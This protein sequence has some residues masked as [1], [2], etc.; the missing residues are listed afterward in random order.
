[1]KNYK[2]KDLFDLWI[3]G[4]LIETK[5]DSYLFN[6]RFMPAKST[7]TDNFKEIK[8]ETLCRKTEVFDKNNVELFSND[9]IFDGN[10]NL[11]FRIF[12][13]AGGFV[14]KAGVWGDDFEW[15][16]SDELIVESLSDVQTRSYVESNCMCIGNYFNKNK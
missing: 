10:R 5:F 2:A 16:S 6:Q 8:K 7:P 12:E 4:D 1:M 11:K 9:I 15:V 13:I 3:Y 14:I